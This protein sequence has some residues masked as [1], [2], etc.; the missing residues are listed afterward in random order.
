LDSINVSRARALA[1]AFAL[2]V[3]LT[4]GGA[5]ASGPDSPTVQAAPA[6][7]IRVGCYANPETTRIVNNTGSSIQV[8]T[9][10]STYQ[11]YSY[12]PIWV[13]KTLAPGKSIT[14]QT[15]F[16]AVKNVLKRN[17]IYNNNGMDKARVVTSVGTF[18][19]ACA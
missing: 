4:T 15:G 19:K 1:G 8:R 12:E 16:A 13:G 3:V 14:Y 17:Y 5:V 6:I 7:G 18:T 9:V 10:G 11:P 2:A